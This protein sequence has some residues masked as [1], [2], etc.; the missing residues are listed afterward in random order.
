MAR[1]G[2]P[3][4]THSYY[5]RNLSESAQFFERVTKSIQKGFR[6]A[7][8]QGSIDCFQSTNEVNHIAAR[9]RSTSSSAEMRSATKWSRFVNQAIARCRVEK[10]TGARRILR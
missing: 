2:E 10:G 5:L 9:V 6:S 7:S 3:F 4:D 1:N 8:S